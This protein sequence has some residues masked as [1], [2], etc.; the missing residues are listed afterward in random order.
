MFDFQYR[1]ELIRIMNE[2]FDSGDRTGTGTRK[3]WSANFELDLEQEKATQAC[4]LP[5]LTTRKVFPRTAYYE[6]LWML[7]GNTDANWLKERG[8]GIWNGNT[9][10]EF[11]DSRGLTHLREGQ[12]GKGYGH[13]FRNFSGVDQLSNVFDGLL[14][15]PDGRRHIISLWNPAELDEMAL[16]PCHMMYQFGVT[17]DLLN[18]KFYQRS[19]DMILGVPM[20]IMFSAMFLTIAAKALGY[21]VGKLSHSMGDAHIYHNHFQAAEYLIDSHA[22]GPYPSFEIEVPEYNTDLGID[23]FL[24]GLPEWEGVKLDYDSNPPLDK[25]LLGMAV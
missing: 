13:Q 20:N 23:I 1:R 16:P 24:Q 25:S 21:R 2:G 10:R 17:D 11:L 14:A 9:S 3:V 4:L 22:R 12:I 5:A 7:S 8:I 15:D 18:L 6:L 19:A